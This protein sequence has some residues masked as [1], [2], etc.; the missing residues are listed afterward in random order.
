M[1]TYLSLYKQ[2]FFFVLRFAF[3]PQTLP[4]DWGRACFFPMSV[5]YFILTCLLLRLTMLMAS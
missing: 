3:L 4:I 1:N 2:L 5:T